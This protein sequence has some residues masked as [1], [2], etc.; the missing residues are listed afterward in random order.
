MRKTKMQKNGLVRIGNTQIYVSVFSFIWA[1]FAIL[2]DASVYTLAV[3]LSAA[4]HEA[5]HIFALSVCH[6]KPRKIYV[7]PFGVDMK[8]SLS[9][10]S[11]KQEL[12]VLL[13]GAG[14]N[15]I[16]AAVSFA[17]C[18]FAYNRISLFIVFCNAFLG[19][20]NLFPVSGL[21]GGRALYALLCMHLEEE[22][23]CRICKTISNASYAV[24]SA[25][26]LFVIVFTKANFSMI[27]MLSLF[28][29]GTIIASHL[30]K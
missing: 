3:I 1:S 27:I 2:S 10:L 9:R 15:F 4:L 22:K 25:V 14:A 5:G 21:D 28:A 26:F 18:V 20:T 30:L 6:E 8:C 23:A 11:Y 13:S 24:M 7:Y 16:T 19:I 12:F 29:M 17:V